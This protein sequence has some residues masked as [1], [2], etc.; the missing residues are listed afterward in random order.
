MDL[1]QQEMDVTSKNNL[2][3]GHLTGGYVIVDEDWIVTACNEKAS[4][5]LDRKK[6]AMIGRHCR[7]IFSE[8][9]R[10]KTRWI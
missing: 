4:L 7:E 9:V 1:L 6:T 10:L 2:H 5:I 8:D 3:A